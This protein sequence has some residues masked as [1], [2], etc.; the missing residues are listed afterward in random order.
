M[1]PLLARGAVTRVR[2]D[3]RLLDFLSTATAHPAY[4]AEYARAALR[5]G[6]GRARPR[7][8]R[9][10]PEPREPPWSRAGCPERATEQTSA[11][12]PETPGSVGRAAPDPRLAPPA[13]VGED[14]CAEGL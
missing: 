4:R 14:F 10:R 5:V 6:P 3:A 13:D 2:T 11:A 12:T 9:R 8:R 7:R 1:S